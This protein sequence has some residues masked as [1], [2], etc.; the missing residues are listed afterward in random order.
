MSSLGITVCAGSNR[1]FE[2]LNDADRFERTG[3]DLGGAN[4][5]GL[6]LELVLE[7]FGVSQNHAQLV[8]Q[9][10]KEVHQVRR[11]GGI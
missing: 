2:V 4:P 5:L 7:E 11:H 6:V 1:M 8:V 3:H 10:V 9:A